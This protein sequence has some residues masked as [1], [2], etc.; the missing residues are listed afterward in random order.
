MFEKMSNKERYRELCEIE[1]S[2]PVFAQAWWLDAAAGSENWNVVLKENA[3]QIEAALPFFKKK[4]IGLTILSVPN[5]TPSLGP[6]LRP[7]D[8]KLSKQLA[9]EKD[10]LTYLFDALPPHD[11][12]QQNWS[13]ERRN[14]LPL[15]W[16]RYTQ[17]TGYTYRLTN[18]QDT[19][20]IW[21]AMDQNNRNDIR[22]AR[23]R[24]RVTARL[25]KSTSEV[26]DVC[27]KT[28]E[29]QKLAAPYTERYLDNLLSAA[30]GRNAVDLL[31]A[32]GP[33]GEIHA[34]A[35]ILYGHGVAYYILGGGDPQYR[36]SGA[37]SL[38]LWEAIQRSS[39]RVQ[40]FDFEGSMIESI[41][42]F[43]RGFGGE[44]TPYLQI[45]KANTW[46]GRAFLA[47][48]RVKKL[49]LQQAIGG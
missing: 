9:R 7:C 6:W 28:F 15:Y 8:G 24:E 43:F 37:A 13:V 1:S 4:R 40:T 23:D 39:K 41:E 45:Q 12:Y 36:N 48:Q 34:G 5:L 21:E 19:G 3:G 25:A 33:Q 14:W 29:R 22:K 35:I 32:E 27:S 47:A 44:L 17:S 46:R 49:Q 20:S 38:L 18:L 26:V 31:V 16:K 42:R 10:L 2:I 11:V 30:A